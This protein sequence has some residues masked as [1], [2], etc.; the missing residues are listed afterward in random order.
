VALVRT[1]A[2]VL[3]RR[4][5]A[6]VA[7]YELRDLPAD[8]PVIGDVNNRHLGMFT[9]ARQPKPAAAAFAF[10]ARL[11][12][13]PFQELGQEARV[14]PPA[15][16]DLLV[17][18]FRFDDGE[19]AAIAWLRTTPVTEPE[20]PDGADPRVR[21]VRLELPVAVPDAT[22]FDATGRRLASVPLARRERG[23]VAELTIRGGEV[24]VLIA[25]GGR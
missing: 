3:A 19:V 2:L 8:E 23:A 17:R 18:A 1:L 25:S 21:R 15:P 4:E 10:M 7:W 5:I 22:L 9:P 24:A 14:L 20:A 13:R 16:A 11:F 6:L 12:A